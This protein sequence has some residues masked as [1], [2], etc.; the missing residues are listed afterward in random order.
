MVIKF[1]EGVTLLAHAQSRTRVGLIRLKSLRP[2]ENRA[3]RA[4]AA[5]P[6]AGGK[7]KISF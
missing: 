6:Y 3:L 7:I 5:I 4:T 1:Y 2:E